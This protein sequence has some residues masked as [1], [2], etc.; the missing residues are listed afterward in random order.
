MAT[1]RATSAMNTA[2]AEKPSPGPPNSS[3]T[4]SSQKPAALALCMMASA[5]ASLMVRRSNGM[6]SRSMNRRRLRR[7]SSSSALSGSRCVIVIAGL[8]LKPCARGRAN[9][10]RAAISC[11]SFD[12]QA[13]AGHR[14]IRRSWASCSLRSACLQN[15]IKS[16]SDTCA[17]VGHDE[18]LDRL[19]PLF[20]WDA[21]DSGV[22]DFRMAVKGLL[23]LTRIDV[24]A[25]GNDD[26][27]LAVDDEQKAVVVA[28][29]DIAGLQPAVVERI[30]GGGRIVPI[31]A[32]Q[33][34]RVG[35]DF[36]LNTGRANLA[37][38]VDN[39][40]R[41]RRRRDAGGRQPPNVLVG[42][43]QQCWCG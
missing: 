30:E 39:L 34:R 35:D 36:A 17:V 23:D 22:L 41:G 2:I 13:V 4:S 10:A 26:F 15:A 11:R 14:R 3:G 21:D 20:V 8:A 12:W 6:I 31:T 5:S 24:F 1:V 43:F 40:D 33:A 32:Q 25:A 16:S 37:V 9:T 19:A 29:A 42:T 38:I 27:L 18:S 7:N 28:P